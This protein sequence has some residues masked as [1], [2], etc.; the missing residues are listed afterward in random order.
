MLPPANYTF[1]LGE[2]VLITLQAA[3][4]DDQAVTDGTNVVAALKQVIGGEVPPDDAPVLYNFDVKYFAPIA[5]GPGVIATPARW[6]MMMKAGASS[7]YAPGLYCANA[8]AQLPDGTVMITRP[9]FI[10]FE[11]AT[12]QP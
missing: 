9:V 7:G 11:R 2:T 4:T 6:E 8:R 1:R 10:A 5:A 12:V 3:L